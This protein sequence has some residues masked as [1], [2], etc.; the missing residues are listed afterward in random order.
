MTMNEIAIEG[1]VIRPG[2]DGYDEQRLPWQR[3]FDPRPALI[4]EAAGPDDV[5]AAIRYAREADLPLAVQATGHGTVV[6][7]DD[8]LLLKTGALNSVD[9]DPRNASARVGAGALWS[10]VI[11]ATP[12][13]LAPLS[14]SAATVAVGGY[15]LGGGAGWLSRAYG[16]A[17]DSL[18]NAEV[19]TADG[20]RLTASAD[21]NPDLFWALRGGGGNFGVVTELEFRLHPAERLYGGMVMFDADNA[22][23]TL[24]RYREWAQSEPDES[25]SAVVVMNMP[26]IP[27]VPEPVRGKRVL[28]VRAIYLGDADAGARALEP[29]LEAA[30]TPLMG[31]MQEMRYADTATL[32][33]PA[34]PPS[35]AEVRFALLDD[36]VDEALDVLADP[37]LGV[38]AVELRHW[39]GAMSNPPEGAG[40]IGHRD[41]PFSVAINAVVPERV[42]LAAAR[43][44]A[45]DVM[46]RL[47]PYSTGGSLL[48]FL[49]DPAQTATAYTDAD[50]TR[51]AQIKAVYDPEN[52]FSRGHVIP[53]AS[54]SS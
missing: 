1:R 15:T 18:L 2:E 4:V 39:G 24:A 33:G 23:A 35:V 30:G 11:A 21:E 51:L 36:V 45:D 50:Y 43:T 26:P 32:L 7:A 6:A 20:E 37:A 54:G 41:V 34:P 10:D 8:A 27:Q 12:D 9:V 47:R 31:G 49:S 44:A 48:N 25:N 13:G 22:H 46:R 38:T 19:I 40:P 3:R 16:F 42:Q 29:L 14:G 28:A 53:P 52:V 17:A 5:Q